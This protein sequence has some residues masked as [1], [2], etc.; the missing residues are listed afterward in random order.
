MK[1]K[2]KE[3]LRIIEVERKWEGNSTL[4]KAPFFGFEKKKK[5]K[6]KEKETVDTH[7]DPAALHK[8]GKEEEE[9]FFINRTD[10]NLS[11]FSELFDIFLL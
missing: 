6:R 8:K 10:M 7:T 3:F 11:N 2:I 9:T 5:E 1:R 4:K